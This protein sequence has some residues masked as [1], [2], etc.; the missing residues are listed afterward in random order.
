MMAITHTVRIMCSNWLFNKARF[1]YSGQ[2]TLIHKCRE[3][4]EKVMVTDTF[5]KLVKPYIDSQDQLISVDH[6]DE[7]QNIVFKILD[8]I[9]KND[10][11]EKDFADN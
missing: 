2:N 11:I 3:L 4:Q 10:N 1:K 8:N 6:F 5:K 7:L 9:N